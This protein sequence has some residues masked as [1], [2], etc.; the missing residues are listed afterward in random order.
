MRLFF[1]ALGIFSITITIIPFIK[2]NKWWIRIFDYPRFQVMAFSIISLVGILYLDSLDHNFE[3]FLVFLLLG[4]LCYQFLI[5]LPYTPLYKSQVKGTKV[6]K[7]DAAVSL[8]IS[9]VLMENKNYKKLLDIFKDCDP[10][11]IIAVETDNWWKSKLDVLKKDYPNFI[12]YPLNNTYGM[13]L[14]SK[15]D[16]FDYQVRFLVEDDIPSIFTKVKLKNGKTALLYA[17]HPTPPVPGENS[18]IKV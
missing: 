8:V 11:I 16:L 13:L 12:S 18:L 4:T 17:L 9:N 7:S 2:S 1:I 10:D 6:E 5:I 15:L 3:Y 14:Y